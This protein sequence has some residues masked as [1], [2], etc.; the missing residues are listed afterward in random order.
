MVRC[1]IDRRN[2]DLLG[3]WH[4][5]QGATGA[6]S[7]NDAAA[8]HV[9]ALSPGRHLTLIHAVQRPIE[10]PTI[11]IDGNACLPRAFGDTFVG[12]RGSVG[13]DIH[14]TGTA[15][16]HGTRTDTVDDPARPAWEQVKRTAPVFTRHLDYVNDVSPVG[17]APDDPLAIGHQEIG[18]TK[19]HKI[20]Y[21][22]IA[23]TRCREHY[24]FMPKQLQEDPDLITRSSAGG[25]TIDVPSTARPDAP[26]P[27]Y[28]IPTYGWT[29]PTASK[30]QNGKRTTARDRRGGGLRVYLDRPWLSSGE[31]E[32]LGA[33]IW[34]R[35]LDY[36]AGAN[37]ELAPELMPYVSQWGMDP[38]WAT[39][40][41]MQQLKY[42]LTPSQFLNT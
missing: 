12:L 9:W 2:L 15:D 25:Q 41:N 33:V 31:R 7:E 6:P 3:V 38:I 42:V 13:V 11:S 4:W 39:R 28:V 30:T 24:A 18:D 5:L 22:A 14:S 40:R 21:Q 27:L 32:M 35:A 26:I 1:T 8:G 36:F 19:H 16:V 23:T 37:N 20:T 10:A 34:P 17:F 29:E